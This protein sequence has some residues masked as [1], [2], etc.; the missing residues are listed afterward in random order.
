APYPS[1]YTVY[2]P[3]TQSAATVHLAVSDGLVAGDTISWVVNG[4][5]WLTDTTSGP[6]YEATKSIPL[7][8]T[9][10]YVRAEVRSLSGSQKAMTQAIF[11]VSTSGLPLG[12]S[13]YVSGV[14]TADGKGY[15]KISTKGIVSASWLSASQVLSLTLSDPLQSLIQVNMVT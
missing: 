13:F 10:T 4:S 7:S 1:R 6:S 3:D 2:V 15:T 9:R 14:T 5:P 11:F 12:D 8:G